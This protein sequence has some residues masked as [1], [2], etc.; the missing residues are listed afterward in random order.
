MSARDFLGENRSGVHSCHA[1]CE[2]QSSPDRELVEAA[3]KAHFEPL[4]V[5]FL[6]TNPSTKEMA[7]GR[8]RRTIAAVV[9]LVEAAVL[10][11]VEKAV[12]AE[13]NRPGWFSD[14]SE[15]TD[16]GK[17]GYTQGWLDA[18]R[19]FYAAL[20]SLGKDGE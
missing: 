17:A 13:W 16:E 3:T 19:A 4:G 20:A 18:T 9:P 11:R 1:G 2:C 15:D 14:Q 5:E 12:E 8:W 10:G 6:S 7:G